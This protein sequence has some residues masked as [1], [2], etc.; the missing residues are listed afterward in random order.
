MSGIDLRDREQIEFLSSSSA[1]LGHERVGGLP[2]GSSHPLKHQGP[3]GSG[4]HGRSSVFFPTH[5]QRAYIVKRP[6]YSRVYSTSMAGLL[7]YQPHHAWGPTTLR[8]LSQATLRPS[9]IGLPE[10]HADDPNRSGECSL[11]T[12]RPQFQWMGPSRFRK[13]H[14][15]GHYER[16]YQ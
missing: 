1:N 2:S 10:R 5:H 7:P 4:T 3:N 12:K 15:V 14:Q 9:S 13:C 16:Q 6:P 8:T 11:N